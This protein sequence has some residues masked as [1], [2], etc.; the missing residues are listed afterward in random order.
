[1][2]FRA[3][4][5]THALFTQTCDVL[6]MGGAVSASGYGHAGS[7][8]TTSGVPCRLQAASAS[9]AMSLGIERG[10]ATYNLYMPLTADVP[11]LKTTDRV[12]IGS[13]TFEALGPGMEQGEGTRIQAVPVRDVHR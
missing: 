10:Q 4:T 5:G 13:R 6:R 9:E 7:A 8:T 3:W 11:A 2:S 12:S 1:M